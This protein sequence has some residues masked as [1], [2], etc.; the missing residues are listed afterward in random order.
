MS[1]RFLCATVAVVAFMSLTSGVCGADPSE[2]LALSYTDENGTMP[3]RL[4]VPPTYDPAKQYPL[5]L[6]LH[7][8]GEQGSDNIQQVNGNINNLFTH[9]KMPQYESLLLAPQTAVGWGSLAQ[10]T[11]ARN[12]AKHVETQYSIAGD[13]VFC[14]GLSMGGGGV[15]HISVNFPEDFDAYVPICGQFSY[16]LL[17]GNMAHKPVWAFHAADDGTVNVITTRAMVQAI[18]NEG[19]DPLYTEYPTGGHGIWGTVY[20]TTALYDWMYSHPVARPYGPKMA[21]AA[22]DLGGG[23]WGFLFTITNNDGK[24]LPYTIEMGFEGVNGATIQQVL[25]NDSMAIHS[26]TWA[27]LVDGTGGYTKALD[28]WVFSPFGDNALPGTN[29]L[30][31]QPLSGFYEAANAFAMSCHSGF[32]STLGDGVNLAYVVADGDVHWT[33][34][35]TRDD[36]PF[37]TEGATDVLPDLPGDYNGD[38]TVSGAD[39]VVWADTFGNDGSAGKEDLRADGNGDGA[40]SGADYVIWADNFGATA[41]N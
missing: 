33:G 41:G 37:E 18:R 10:V 30:T 5:V 3:Y 27:N 2:F 4:Y 26:E 11:L 19:Y 39:Y 22:Q 1:K 34:A 6:F 32:G 9:V 15:W 31:G 8:L 28:T 20:N 14:T 21:Y 13:Q 35:I 7:G 29:P 40:V 38:G 25:Y 17:A 16:V 36:N 12:I 24:L 23:L